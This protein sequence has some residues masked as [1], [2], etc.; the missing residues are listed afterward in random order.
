[1]SCGWLGCACCLQLCQSD[2]SDCM[3]WQHARLAA[4]CQSCGPHGRACQPAI[5]PVHPNDL[6]TAHVIPSHITKPLWAAA[7]VS[8]DTAVRPVAT[9]HSPI[10]INYIRYGQNQSSTVHAVLPMPLP[11]RLSLET[12]ASR[13]VNSVMLTHEQQH[14]RE[15]CANARASNALF[16]ICN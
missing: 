5:Q 7:P 11:I 3:S 14:T 15:C 1:M 10:P 9:S 4:G 2:V 6:C 16:E 12:W 13:A 8:A